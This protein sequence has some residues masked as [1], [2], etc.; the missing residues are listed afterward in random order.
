MENWGLKAVK[1]A[2]I[3]GGGSFT[4]PFIRKLGLEHELRFVT[5]EDGLTIVEWQTQPELDSFDGIVQGGVMNVI[6]DFAQ[7]HAFTSTLDKPAAFSTIDM[8][9][10]FV[11]SVKSGTMLTVKSQV[12]SRTRSGAIIETEFLRPDGQLT[13]KVT[14][15]WQIVDRAFKVQ[16]AAA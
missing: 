7:A 9:T 16:P 6:A 15:G 12:T 5:I 13:T 10:R 1:K 11:R 3:E 8:H 14:G 2:T 4:L